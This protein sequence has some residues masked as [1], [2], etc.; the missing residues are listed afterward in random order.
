MHFYQHSI[1]ILPD[2]SLSNVHVPI[3]I[4]VFLYRKMHIFLWIF[5]KQQAMLPI[6]QQLPVAVQD[7]LS[8][9]PSLGVDFCILHVCRVSCLVLSAWHF[10]GCSY[11]SPR[12]LMNGIHSLP[13]E[14]SRDLVCVA[15][16]PQCDQGDIPWLC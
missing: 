16:I 6:V 5:P 1:L 15:L 2:T 12:T 11:C 3:P 10:S 8:M 13:L 7:I 4:C 9:I 14:P